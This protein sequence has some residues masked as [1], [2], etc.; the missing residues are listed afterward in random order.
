MLE[1]YSEIFSLYVTL[2]KIRRWYCL[3]CHASLEVER[4][5]FESKFNFIWT[6]FKH[7]GLPRTD[8]IIEGVIDQQHK[9]TDCHGFE[10]FETAW[11]CLKMVIMNYRFHKFTCSR[12]KGHN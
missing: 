11:N 7:P 8:N 5:N 9:I 1:N 12:L 2:R 3:T 10:H 4:L 6:H